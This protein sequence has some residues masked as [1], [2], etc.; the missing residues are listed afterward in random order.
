MTNCYKKF[1]WEPKMSYSVKSE[2]LRET[3]PQF[4]LWFKKHI[5]STGAEDAEG[6]SCLHVYTCSSTKTPAEGD[7]ACI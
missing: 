5:Y 6:T 7:K 1:L 3:L 2:N 4:N